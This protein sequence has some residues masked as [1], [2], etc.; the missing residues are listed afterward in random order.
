EQLLFSIS[1]ATGGVPPYSYEWIFYSVG[2][3]S[4]DTVNGQSASYAFKDAGIHYVEV[5]VMDSVGNKASATYT[6]KVYNPLTISVKASSSTIYAGLPVTF[7]YSISGGSGKYNVTYNLGNGVT[8]YTGWSKLSAGSVQTVYMN[9][10]QYLAAFEVFDYAG[11]RATST[12]WVNVSIGQTNATI[13]PLSVYSVLNTKPYATKNITSIPEGKQLYDTLYVKGGTGWYN[14]TVIWGDGGV[15][16]YSSAFTNNA[17]PFFK[18]IYTFPALYII[19]VY[20]NDSVGTSAYDQQVIKVTYVPPSVNIGYSIPYTNSPLPENFTV[21]SI[22]V[23][24]TVANAGIGLWGNIS[25]GK[26]PYVWTLYNSTKAIANGSARSPFVPFLIYDFSTNVPGTY[27]FQLNIS[28][29]YG[30]NATAT[31]TIVVISSRLQVLLTN[32]VGDTVG[33][34]TPVK[35][36]VYLMN[37]VANASGD[38]NVTVVFN[39]GTVATPAGNVTIH[40]SWTGLVPYSINFAWPNPLNITTLIDKAWQN[41]QPG[42]AT[43]VTYYIQGTFTAFVTANYGTNFN[44]STAAPYYFTEATFI[45]NVMPLKPLNYVA[46]WSPYPPVQY[47]GSP[48]VV[49]LNI[50]GGNGL[51]VLNISNI[52]GINIIL[53][54]YEYGLVTEES[55]SAY[56]WLNTTVSSITPYNNS[57][58]FNLTFLMY[59]HVAGSFLFT[60]VLQDPSGL[61]KVNL[62]FDFNFQ[63]LV[64][65]PLNVTLTANSHYSYADY[66]T[67]TA[68]LNISGSAP[69]YTINMNFGGCLSYLMVY[70]NGVYIPQYSMANMLEI[71][72]S[73][74]SV[75]GGFGVSGHPGVSGYPQ[76]AL[77][78][79]ETGYWYIAEYGGILVY[80]PSV[81]N[82]P[83]QYVGSISGVPSPFNTFYSNMTYINGFIYAM[84]YGSNNVLVINATNMSVAKIITVGSGPQWPGYNAKAQILYVPNYW[85]DNISLISVVNNTVFK[86]FDLSGYSS[87]IGTGP[88]GIAYIPANNELYVTMWDSGIVAVLNATT[89]RLIT[90][91][92]V[93]NNPEQ[94]IFDPSNGLV[95]ASGTGTGSYYYGYNVTVFNPVQNVIVTNITTSYGDTFG[96]QYNPVNKLVYVAEGGGGVAIISNTTL[97]NEI[98]VGG[99]PLQLAFNSLDG[100]MYVVSHI[101]VPSTYPS[102]Y[103]FTFSSSKTPVSF[104]FVGMYCSIPDYALSNHQIW[105][106]VSSSYP[107]THPYFINVSY[108]EYAIPYI[109][110]GLYASSNSGIA[111]TVISFDATPLF[112]ELPNMQSYVYYWYLLN[113]ENVPIWNTTTT[114]SAISIPFNVPGTYY[115]EVEVMSPVGESAKAVT[116]P[117][118]ISKPQVI[119]QVVSVRAMITLT[120]PSGNTYIAYAGPVDWNSNGTIFASFPMPNVPTV[121]QVYTMNVSYSYTLAITQYAYYPGSSVNGGWQTYFYNAYSPV[122]YASQQITVVA[123]GVLVSTG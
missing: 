116:G 24:I 78:V 107:L 61:P 123:G 85:S 26:A 62:P 49:S 44:N 68:Y 50:T 2:N 46:Y 93:G 90:Y 30:N 103:K 21:N 67:F 28:D 36:Y 98:Y 91:F 9:L 14:Y 110:T 79:P 99:D 22:T 34:G 29:S 70:R 19:R 73:T 71:S 102:S 53:P 8:G 74:L 88:E 75:N 1:G 32:N 16:Y 65:K 13:A 96:I 122:P 64:P 121:N 105:A 106:N 92:N 52:P 84:N 95:Y 15:S 82:I 109:Q 41:N 48:I 66:S 27:H 47:I 35:Y 57:Y 25:Y 18:H 31:F 114:T 94:I 89:G 111:P 76:S 17:T 33:V 118:T 7:Y 60:S 58:T 56:T 97:V 77:F 104:T 37:V 100:N 10:G 86:T 101:N 42:N 40:I 54:S 83:A 23:N 11:L 43:N 63:F 51:Y 117:I 119:V 45:I 115:V 72:S 55:N 12:Y 5:I 80:T 4:F 38:A 3:T 69:P 20:V 113:S 120:N 108:D 6:V 39:N 81:G 59:G 87:Y 112:G